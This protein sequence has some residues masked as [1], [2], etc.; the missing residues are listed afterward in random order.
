MSSQI[1]INDTIH[2]YI[3]SNSLRENNLLAALRQATLKTPHTQMLSAA[4]EV[5]FITLLLKMLKAKNVIEVG[6]FTGYTTLAMAL[7]LP[8]DGRVIACDI[9]DEWVKLGQPFWQQ[10]NVSNKIDLRI[11][12]AAD[13]LKTLGAQEPEAFDLIYIDADKQGYENYYELSLKLIRK[14]G[15]IL[16]DNMLRDGKV[17]D[18]H[19]ND[20]ATIHIRN[21][22]QKFHH[23]SRVD[24]SL[25]PLAD[26]VGVCVKN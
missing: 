5:Q 12:P 7:T 25:L 8:K 4:D 22:T 23:D 13:T 16:L 17:A 18:K 14:G 2:Q 15:V 21:L 1:E 26:G 10:A 9:S 11:A 3:V 24:F 20:D 19:C 6:V